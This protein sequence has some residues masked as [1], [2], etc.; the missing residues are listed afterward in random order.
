M[1]LA[2]GFNLVWLYL[3]RLVIHRFRQ[4]IQSQG[5]GVN[6]VALIGYDERGKQLIDAINNKPDDGYNLVGI[7]GNFEGIELNQ[8]DSSPIQHLGKLDAIL[9]LVEIHRID[10]TF[11]RFSYSTE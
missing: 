4:A 11:H 7:I 3:G 5:V 2:T 9:K 1:L 6:R 10:D 8:D